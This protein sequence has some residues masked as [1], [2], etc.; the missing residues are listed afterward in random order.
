MENDLSNN[1][2]CNISPIIFLG[3][4]FQS[5]LVVHTSF[6]LTY[7]IF[8]KSNQNANLTLYCYMS[9]WYHSYIDLLSMRF[10]P[11]FQANFKIETFIF[12]PQRFFSDLTFIKFS[13]KFWPFLYWARGSYEE[14]LQLSIRETH[15][16]EE[17][18]AQ[19]TVS[20]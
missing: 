19:H 17:I 10:L 8:K 2:N 16:H 20:F 12:P 4:I 11:W 15:Y 6:L 14:M 13:K 9:K 7:F 18:S 5:C 1:K 3:S